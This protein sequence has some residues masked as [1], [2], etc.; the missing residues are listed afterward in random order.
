METTELTKSLRNRIS[1][2]V[3][4]NGYRPAVILLCPLNISVLDAAVP[5]PSTDP[6]HRSFEGIPVR[7]CTDL[8]SLETEIL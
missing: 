4:A 3:H 6:K 8:K 7:K 1:T 2:F 5:V